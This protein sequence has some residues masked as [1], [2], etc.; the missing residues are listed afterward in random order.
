MTARSEARMLDLNNSIFIANGTAGTRSCFRHCF[1]FCRLLSN[2]ATANT[3]IPTSSHAK[4]IIDLFRTK[5]TPV[6]SRRFLSLSWSHKTAFALAFMI[7]ATTYILISPAVVVCT[8]EHIRRP[9]LVYHGIFLPGCIACTKHFRVRIG[10]M[11]DL[12][13]CLGMWSLQGRSVRF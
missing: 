8:L 6:N 7:G 5:S 1:S 4:W 13:L 3:T 11:L 12:C 9:R 2:V 10:C